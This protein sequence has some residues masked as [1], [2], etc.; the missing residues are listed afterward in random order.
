MSFLKLGL[1]HLAVVHKEPERNRQQLFSICREAGERGVQLLVA[2]EMAI[3]GYAFASVGEMAPYAETTDGPT[4]SGVG[5]ICRDYGIHA[6]IGLAERD[7]STGIL[8]NSAFV[9]DPQGQPVLRYRKMNAEFR[10]ACPGDPCEDNTFATPWGRVGVLIC[11]DSYHSLMPRV[12][13]LRGANLLL[14]LANWPPVGGLDPVEIWR[15]RAVENG[16]FVAVCNRTGLDATMDCRMAPSALISAQGAVQLHKKSRTSKL[17]RISVPL[18]GEGQLKSGQRLKR[19]SGRNRKRMHGCYL[20]RSGIDDLG[21]FLNLPPVGRLHVHAHCPDG[22]AGLHPALARIEASGPMA[23]TLHILPTGSYADSDIAGL[24]VWCAA[25]G[26][27]AVLNRSTE[28]GEVL[29]WFDGQGEPRSRPWD[30]IHGDGDD[31][32]PVFDCGA[33]RVHVVPGCAL[34][35]PELVLACAKQGADLVLIF[36]RVFNERVCLLAGARTIEQTTVLVSSPQGTGI[37]ST[38]HGHQRWSETLARPG[39]HC[40]AV[41]DTTITRRKRFQDRIDYQTLFQKSSIGSKQEDMHP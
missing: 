14:V 33:A 23:E 28:A 32:W 9:I 41:L 24:R 29:Y 13:A 11:S 17:I 26:Q 3:S 18:N 20:N 5:A 16:F 25:T 36:N 7:P 21:S 8:Y 35:H 19:L 15:A 22:Q 40:T 4:L 1:L 30:S 2:P 6:C 10:W 31:P 38:P 37:W 27:W 12:T 39:E 34:F